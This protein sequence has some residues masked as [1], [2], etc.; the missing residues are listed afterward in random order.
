MFII[1]TGPYL[2]VRTFNIHATGCPFKS[3]SM[4]F[5]IFNFCFNFTCSY[6]VNLSGS[7]VDK[8]LFEETPCTAQDFTIILSLV[9]ILLGFY[10]SPGWKNIYWVF[11]SNV[12]KMKGPPALAK[13]SVLASVGELDPKKKGF[14]ERHEKAFLVEPRKSL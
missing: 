5:C 14:L 9:R 3:F 4:G 13:T 8:V 1:T 12:N 11:I 10:I 7:Y 2:H 6:C